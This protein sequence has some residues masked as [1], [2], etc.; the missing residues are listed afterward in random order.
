MKIRF[1]ADWDL[2]QD[3]LTGVIRREPSVD[4]KTAAEADLSGVKDPDVLARA[5][6]E[7]RLLVTHDGEHARTFP[8]LCSGEA[9]SGCPDRPAGPCHSGRST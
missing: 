9:V 4:F 8:A 6:G 2:N 7:G 5:A 1:Q 3:I